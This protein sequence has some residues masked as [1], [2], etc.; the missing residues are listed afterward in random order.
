[1][2]FKTKVKKLTTQLTNQQ[3]PTAAKKKKNKQSKVSR[4]SNR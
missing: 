4:K 1:M 2:I 3:K